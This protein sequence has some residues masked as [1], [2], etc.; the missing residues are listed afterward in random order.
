MGWEEDRVRTHFWVGWMWDRGES[1]ERR[2]P[3]LWEQVLPL[4]LSWHCTHNSYY[5][6]K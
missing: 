3:R 1:K 4:I 2:T 5:T 6:R